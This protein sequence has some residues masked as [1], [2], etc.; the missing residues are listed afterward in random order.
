MRAFIALSLVAAAA[1]AQPLAV[2]TDVANGNSVTLTSET[3][4][5]VNG[6]RLALW[7]RGDGQ[8]KVPGCYL[9]LPDGV[10]IA[11]LDGDRIDLPHHAFKKP[12]KS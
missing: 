2:A 8:A 3:G 10:R 7:V 6:A 9:I 5:C 4:P 11:F 12:A 1:Q